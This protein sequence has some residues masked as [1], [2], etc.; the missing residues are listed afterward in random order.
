[1]RRRQGEQIAPA[2]GV[3][4]WT[5][6]ALLS[7]ERMPPP[8]ELHKKANTMNHQQ[9]RVIKRH[10]TA[11]NGSSESHNGSKSKC[12]QVVPSPS[13]PDI[14]A[15]R[16]ESSTVTDPN[17]SVAKPMKRVHHGVRHE[18]NRRRDDDET[19]TEDDDV[20][21]RTAKNA[22]ERRLEKN[23]VKVTRGE[24]SSDEDSDASIED[25]DVEYDA[26]IGEVTSKRKS[27]KA[28]KTT[29]D[30]CGNHRVR[31]IDLA[32]S[33]TNSFAASHHI[34]DDDDLEDEDGFENDDFDLDSS[35]RGGAVV[36][37]EQQHVQ[38]GNRVAVYWSGDDE[39]YEGTVTRQGTNPQQK[40]RNNIYVEY[41]DGDCEWVDL[42]KA[43][44]QLVDKKRKNNK[45]KIR[46]DEKETHRTLARNDSSGTS[47]SKVCRKISESNSDLL[48]STGEWKSCLP[49]KT[50]RNS[51]AKPSDKHN[52][53]NEIMPDLQVG[54]RISVWSSITNQYMNGTLVTIDEN[55]GSRGKSIPADIA[56]KATPHYIVYDD[57]DDERTNLARRKFLLLDTRP[58]E[59]A[60]N[61]EEG[62]R[63]GDHN[64]FSKVRRG[65]KQDDGSTGVEDHPMRDGKGETACSDV[66]S[67]I[68]QRSTQA[69]ST[70]KEPEN[71]HARTP[72][73][74]TV[75]KEEVVVKPNDN[76][77]VKVG[78]RVAVYWSGDDEFYDG[79][80]TRHHKKHRNRFYVEYDDGDSEWID[81]RRRKYR[82]SDL[83]SAKTKQ[84]SVR[85]IA[86]RPSTRHEEKVTHR[87][88]LGNVSKLSAGSRVSVWR[89][90]GREYFKGTVVSIDPITSS[91]SESDQPHYV[92]YDDGDSEHT[93]LARRKFIILHGANGGDNDTCYRRSR[94]RKSVVNPDGANDGTVKHEEDRGSN[95][96]NG[97]SSNTSSSSDDDASHRTLCYDDNPFQV[98][99]KIS[100]YWSGDDDYYEGRVTKQNRKRDRLHVEYD[101]GDREWVDTK[102]R[103]VRAVGG[104]Q[105]VTLR[106]GDGLAPTATAKR[107]KRKVNPDVKRVSVG[108]RVSVW[109][110]AENEYYDSTVKRIKAGSSKPHRLAYDD[111]DYE[112]TNLAYRKFILLA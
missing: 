52:D 25:D 11:K 53:V 67:T 78:S 21:V 14:A 63:E 8:R 105:G 96:D 70:D 54:C 4:D 112:K 75:D 81:L 31:G 50:G 82:R 36:G 30:A 94:Q 15:C 42:E 35:A 80:V 90:K 47:K 100:V 20:E 33:A 66:H 110:P 99:E 71:A 108:S 2:K 107:K 76:D 39:Y 51:C 95:C 65:M 98:G 6:T 72:R 3:G 97:S 45:I 58:K 38:V 16:N 111:G 68:P 109:W 59:T 13:E 91:A 18:D 73:N 22:A 103:K 46:G 83:H 104:K 79:M 29:S 41:D 24:S 106:Q 88:R 19:E 28:A 27:R 44:V 74:A 48:E 37:T 102:K 7:R 86:G 61:T 49:E 10:V 17:L 43:T 55:S 12:R 5:T 84:D 34:N 89:S 92:V 9:R 56:S 64:A 62:L 93:N 101:D 87:K 69:P 77:A 26:G 32:P 85:A 1:M 23:C 40:K 60:S 57:G